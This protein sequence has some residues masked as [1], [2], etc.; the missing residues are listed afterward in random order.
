M[1]SAT[2]VMFVTNSGSLLL[3]NTFFR[4]P[5]AV[6]SLTIS[7]ASLRLGVNGLTPFTNIVVATPSG[8]TVGPGTAINIEQIATLSAPTTFNLISYVGTPDPDPAS[9][10]VSVPAG[11]SAGP[12]TVDTANE[13]VTVTI[14]PPAST[15]LAWRGTTNSVLVSNWDTNTPNWVDAAT[16]SISQAYANPDAVRFDDTASNSVVTLLASVTPLGVVVN[17][18]LRNYAFN[19]NGKISGQFNLIKQGISTLTLAETGGDD[20]SGGVVVNG[21]TLILDNTNSAISGGLVI[22]GGATVQIGQNDANGALPLGAV[23]DEGALI[24]SR[25][26]NVTVSTAI[27][28]LGSLT[29]NG[30]GTLTLNNT[31]TYTG[32]TVVSRGKLALT[33]AGTLSNSVSVLVSN[34]TFDVSGAPGTTLLNDLNITNAV[35]N[36]GRTNLQIPLSVTTFEVDGIVASSNII[37]VLALPPVASYPV[38]LPLIR[39]ASGITLAGGNFNFALG[40]LPS[41]VTPY[42]GSL[43]ESA[44]NTTILL[45][46]TAGPTGARPSITWAGTNDISADTNWS[47][48]VNWNLPGAPVATDNLFFDGTTTVGNN[49]IINNVLDGNFTVASL[50]YNQT[51]SGQWHNT[52]IPSGTVL[53]VNG[54]TGVGTGTAAGSTTSATISGGGELDVNGAFNLNGVGGTSDS[55]V[56]LDMSG[57]NIFKNIAPGTTMALGTVAQNVVSLSLASNSIINVATLSLEAT[58]GSNGRAGT[59]NLGA[60]TNTIYANAINIST[61]KGA[62]TK[63]QFGVNAPDGSVVIGGTGGGSARAT[64]IMGNGTSGSAVCNGQLLLAG[65]Y[66]S[67][68][69]G[70][71]TLGGVGGSTGN[72]DL[73]TLTFDNGTFDATSILMGSSTSAHSSSGTF[74]VGGD[75]VHTATLI[76]SSAGSGSFVLGNASISG[77]T[78]AGTLTLNTNG[79]ANVNCSITKNPTAGANNTATINISGGMLNMTSGTIGTPAAPIDNLNLNDGSTLQLSV[80]ANTTNISATAVNPSGITIININSFT[81]V[82]G[83]MQIPLIWY[84]NGLS[85][86]ASLTLGSVPAGYTIGNGGAL[87]DNTANQTVDLIVTAP[88]YV[89]PTINSLVFSG[90]NL[91][92]S[93]TNNSGS[94]GT[95]RVLTSTNITDPFSS[96]TVLTNGTFDGSGNFSSTNLVNTS[97]PQRFFRL[98]VP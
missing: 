60:I 72:G 35:L 89:Q 5:L 71:V 54:A 13:L 70:N 32:M 30:N 69:A 25:S 12:V 58:A 20:F 68:M 23:D 2:N 62:T 3:S 64:M 83:T 67:V 27:S 19:G 39:S 18:D 1:V 6:G 40:T 21:G 53:T 8:L 84:N 63:L 78:G 4:S 48:R 87:V 16:L 10:T 29:Q 36:V 55:H 76:V 52:L 66:A 37:N 33:G 7:N 28:G 9:F 22:D 38:T 98:Q 42:V 11:Y 81:N 43:S 46:L 73:G 15:S 90:G 96:W 17:S 86:I 61:G 91:I 95:Y 80:N 45:T 51:S 59:F 79:V 93:G 31:N 85:P 56:T 57:L 65:H 14:T 97:T 74:T 26:N 94:G 82:T 34:A 77:G 49:A 50:T 44:D 88:V 47:D 75:F 92:I 24:F 41:S